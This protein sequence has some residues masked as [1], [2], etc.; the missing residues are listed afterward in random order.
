MPKQTFFN[1]PDDKR[2][3]IEA[4]AID[5]FAANPYTCASISAIVARAGIAKGSFYQY[6][7]GKKDLY[8]HL[9]KLAN[10]QKGALV[11]QVKPAEKALDTFDYLRWMLQLAF[12]FEVRHPK[13]A[14]IT[15]RSFVEDLP[16]LSDQEG[17]PHGGGAFY[18]ND[19]LSQGILHEDVAPWVDTDMVSFL[20]GI[21]YHFF[22]RYLLKR[23]EL[24][25]EDFA[26]GRLDVFNDQLV[27]DLFDNLMDILE[28]G[29]ARD[30]DIRRQFFSK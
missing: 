6:F 13:L 18:F 21:I 28:A 29:I 24:S 20:L 19:F 14:K 16:F 17:E 10:Q 4:I 15:C 27:Q 11:S 9:L 25:P 1:L 22:G 3:H 26:E 5:E 2:A 7:A 8:Q 23:M 12:L 30:P